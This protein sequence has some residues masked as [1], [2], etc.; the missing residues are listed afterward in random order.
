MK[1]NP[2]AI[3]KKPSTYKQRL[4]AQEWLKLDPEH[5]QTLLARQ[6]LFPNTEEADQT[7]PS[8]EGAGMDLLSTINAFEDE[9]NA[10]ETSP[11]PS[12]DKPS[13]DSNEVDPRLSW[14]DVLHR[15]LTGEDS[16][17]DLALMIKEGRVGSINFEDI[18]PI[19]DEELSDLW[20]QVQRLE[21]AAIFEGDMIA[22][23]EE[24]MNLK[25]ASENGEEFIYLKDLNLG[26]NKLPQE[27]ETEQPIV[28]PVNL[29]LKQMEEKILEK[30]KDTSVTFVQPSTSPKNN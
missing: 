2:S 14:K 21:D 1:K 18:K 7:S 8:L 26:G 4:A 25:N 11:P 28:M 5:R 22:F 17:D 19:T 23:V 3:K 20:V 30:R 24:F 9:L 27:L 12:G 29:A 16:G 6:K 10:I 13:D 15:A